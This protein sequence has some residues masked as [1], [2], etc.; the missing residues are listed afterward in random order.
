MSRRIRNYFEDLRHDG[1]QQVYLPP[2]IVFGGEDPSVLVLKL[3]YDLLNMNCRWSIQMEH[4][5]NLVSDLDNLFGAP[6][7]LLLAHQVLILLPRI[8][9]LDLLG[10]DLLQELKG[11]AMLLVDAGELLLLV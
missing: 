1:Y 3:F 11:E 5:N 6:A 8:I 10:G 7:S 9:L 4:R 2:Q